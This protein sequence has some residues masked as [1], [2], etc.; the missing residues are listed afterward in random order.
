MQGFM[1]AG[2][3]GRV[4]APPSGPGMQAPQQPQQGLPPMIGVGD[5]VEALCEGWGDS[6]FPGTVREMLPNGD[7]QVL[8][9]GDEPSIS[10]LRPG[11]VRRRAG[12]K[13]AAAVEPKPAELPPAPQ[14]P[15]DAGTGNNHTPHQMGQAVG[16]GAAWM[17]QPQQDGPMHA[18]PVPQ[19]LS[20]QQTGFDFGKA[21]QPQPQP[22]VSKDADLNLVRQAADPNAGTAALTRLYRYDFGPG[23]DVSGPMANLRRRVEVELK[24][25]YTIEVS[26]NILRPEGQHG[27]DASQSHPSR[28]NEHDG[29]AR[30]MGASQHAPAAGTMPMSSTA[31]AAAGVPSQQPPAAQT[32]PQS[33]W[34]L[35]Q[36]SP[37]SQSSQQPAAGAPPRGPPPFGP[38]PSG[39]PPA[40]PPPPGPPLGMAQSM[41]QMQ[42]CPGLQPGA[43]PQQSLPQQPPQQQQQTQPPQSQQQQQQQQQQQCLGRGMPPMMAKQPQQVPQM[44]NPQM[45]G[46]PMEAG[47]YQ[48]GM[49]Q[50]NQPSGPPQPLGGRVPMMA[51]QPQQQV[52]Q[53]G[54]PP[55]QG[56]PMEAGMYQP[57]MMQQNQPSG[58]PQPPGGRVPH[59]MTKQPQQVHQQTGNPPMQGQAMDAGMFQQGMMQ[60]PRGPPQPPGGMQGS[61]QM[62]GM[63]PMMASPAQPFPKL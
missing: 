33:Q 58:P 23:D 47:M 60:Q 41:G 10:N 63:V 48:P 38:P 21:S 39:P 30:S 11:L 40:G 43:Q 25:G 18:Q 14:P 24:G 42:A 27:S 35:P 1:P 32:Q 37:P 50:Q 61:F 55:M 16:N 4:Q 46:Q 13:P 6:W 26:L 19:Q 56:Q 3:M 59:M 44:G 7:I 17:H 57:G 28:I 12:A 15:P 29:L 52:Q 54:N 31:P 34:Q 45:Q 20:Q 49:M 2:G 53:M 9:D 51:K 62:P 8:W 36:Q 5:L 22:D